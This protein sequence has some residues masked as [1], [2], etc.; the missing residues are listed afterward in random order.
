[1]NQL[2]AAC[3]LIVCTT[4][5]IRM[6]RGW[7]ALCA[8]IPGI[9]M[10]AITFWAGYLQ[11]VDSY[12][13]NKQYLLAALALLAMLL[14]LVVFVNTFKKWYALTKVKTVLMD[15]HGEEVLARVD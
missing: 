14:M 12:W 10:A 7:L 2:L 5:L 8:A 13:P 6:K 15:K 1:S 9:F 3:G 11:I 4:M